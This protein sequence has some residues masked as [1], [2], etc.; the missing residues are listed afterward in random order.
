MTT[1]VEIQTNLGTFSVELYEQHAPKTC[2]NFAELAKQGYYNNTI[3]HRVIP[4][5]ISFLSFLCMRA[6][7][8]LNKYLY[9]ID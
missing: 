2:Y 5:R 6:C 4:V 9:A 7:M 3:F 1:R 8:Y